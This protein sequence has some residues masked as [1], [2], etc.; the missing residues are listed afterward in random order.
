MRI[1]SA[2]NS[3]KPFGTLDTPGQGET[4]SGTYLNWGWAMTPKPGF[5]ATDGLGVWVGVD[6]VNFAHPVYGLNRSDIAASFPGYINSTTGVGYYLLDTT[7]FANGLHNLGWLIY[8]NL[9]RGDGIGSRF[10][11]IQNTATTGGDPEAALQAERAC[12]LRAARQRRPVAAAAAYP[13]FR[14]G[15]DPEAGLTPIR[16]AGEGLF[17]A[18]ELQELDRLEIHLP[19]GSQWTA[20]MRVGD[21]LR[22]LPIGSTFDA[23]GGIF[24]WQLG[25]V[26]LGEY[27]LEFHAAEGGALCVLA[28]V[29]AKAN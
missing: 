13:A 3:T 29:G 4:I 5:I 18:I 17:E 7:R 16:Q 28:R 12:H 19:G 24:Y 22:P 26:F 23:E 27:Q 11:D 15:Y 1:R 14:R 20:A 25:P 9:N 2:R 8:D 6:G 21:E 10:I